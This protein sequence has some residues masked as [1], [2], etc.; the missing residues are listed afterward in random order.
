MNPEQVAAAERL[1]EAMEAALDAG[2]Y[3]HAHMVV[4]RSRVDG[5]RADVTCVVFSDSAEV[6][7]LFEERICSPTAAEHNR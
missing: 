1:A 6:G 5:K 2:L 3:K 7:A 4:A